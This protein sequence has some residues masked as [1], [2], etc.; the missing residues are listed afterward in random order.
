MNVLEFMKI[1]NATKGM[2][3]QGFHFGGKFPS[4]SSSFLGEEA[5][6]LACYYTIFLR[7]GCS[8][9]M[10]CGNLAIASG[11][12]ISEV[13]WST[14]RLTKSNYGRTKMT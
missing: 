7:K 13:F 12:M 5:V 8:M 9:K 14:L 1:G 4:M 11:H 10:Y 6:L 2:I 3:V